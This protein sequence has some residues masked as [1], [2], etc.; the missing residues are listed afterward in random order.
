MPCVDSGDVY[1]A[2]Q[3]EFGVSFWTGLWQDVNGDDEGPDAGWDQQAR[4]GCVT[5]CVAADGWSVD[6]GACVFLG[7]WLGLG[8][9]ASPGA[10][11]RMGG[12][13]VVVRVY[14]GCVALSG[15]S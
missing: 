2:L 1:A 11:Q 4:S 9:V 13:R 3:D 5:G 7:V 15:A 6:G 14:F 8:R 10:W 12:R